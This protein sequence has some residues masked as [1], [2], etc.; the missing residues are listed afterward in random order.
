MS[1]KVKYANLGHPNRIWAIPAINGQVAP[2]RHLH[3]LL[4]ERFSPGDRLIYMGNYMGGE[5]AQALATLNE[6][7]TFRRHLLAQPGVIPDDFIYLRGSQEDVWSKLLQ[8][9]FAPNPKEV[10]DW[11]VKHYHTEFD[12]LLHAY[13][14]S[15]KEVQRITR[16]GIMSMTKWSVALKNQIRLHPGHE[17]FYTILKRAAFTENLQSNDNNILFVNAGFDPKLSL[18]DQG[19]SFWWHAKGFN[20]ISNPYAPFRSV[21]RGH[22]P[23]H[24]G[25]HV[26]AATVTLDANCGY[27]GTLVAT[28]LSDIGDIIDTIEA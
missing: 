5:N 17:K 10:I 16:E 8:L 20:D 7:L 11:L 6:L 1:F 12:S 14:S 4:I 28:L 15:L 3:S 24:K 25:F 9:Q 21:L 27:G 26:G 18:M 13:N 23:E 19:D 2:L 22:D